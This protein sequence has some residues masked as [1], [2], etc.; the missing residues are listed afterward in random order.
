MSKDEW[1][2]YQRSYYRLHNNRIR[3]RRRARY[4]EHPEAYRRIKNRRRDKNRELIKKYGI[5]IERFEHMLAD[6][7]E[8]CL[9]CRNKLTRWRTPRSIC[10]DHCH[11][12]GTVRGLLCLKCNS[13][14][15]ILGSADV[16]KSLWEYME[17]NKNNGCGC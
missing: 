10:V 9:V 2:A 7:K 5:T 3:A 6:Q 1:A 14:E 16:A 4:R 17:R 13:A 12:T 8:R 11:K 15:A